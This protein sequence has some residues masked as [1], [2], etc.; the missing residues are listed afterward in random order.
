MN[1]ED[2]TIIIIYTPSSRT[3]GY[4]KQKLIEIKGTKNHQFPEPET[5]RNGELDT[6]ERNHVNF[7]FLVVLPHFYI[8]PT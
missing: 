7:L 4:I 8:G 2:I 5:D 3:S 6:T 1:Q